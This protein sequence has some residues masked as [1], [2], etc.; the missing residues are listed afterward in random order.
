MLQHI[1][2]ARASRLDHVNEMLTKQEPVQG[3]LGTQD[4]CSRTLKASMYFARNVFIFQILF[5]FLSYFKF[6]LIKI[7]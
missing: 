3:L 4:E 7:D 5:I 6:V 2:H 1:R